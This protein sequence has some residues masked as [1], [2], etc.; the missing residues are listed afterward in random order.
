MRWAVQ[1]A[2]QHG[3]RPRSRLPAPGEDLAH[4]PRRAGRRV[5]DG[6]DPRP[7]VPPARRHVGEV[8]PADHAARVPSRRDRQTRLPRQPLQPPLRPRRL[9]HAL[10]AVE[11][12][13]AKSIVSGCHPD[14]GAHRARCGPLAGVP[15][16]GVCAGRGDEQR[17]GAGDEGVPTDRSSASR[18]SAPTHGRS[19]PPLSDDSS[20]RTIDAGLARSKRNRQ[21]STE[22]RARRGPGNTRP[23]APR[24]SRQRRRR[25][26]FERRRLLQMADRGR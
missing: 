7:E 15:G 10:D 24:A 11:E 20:S 19:L 3:R 9:D 14:V 5:P 16:C 21:Q 2:R 18:H 12:R 23:S 17:E 4:P 26:L 25:N 22:S 13:R 6:L 1:P 8:P